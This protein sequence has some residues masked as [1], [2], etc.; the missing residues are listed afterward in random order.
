MKKTRKPPAQFAVCVR[1]K[2]YEASLE[3]GKLYRVVPDREA[4][5]HGYLRIV[6]ESGE[7]YGYA[8]DRFFTIE[9]PKP[10]ER[11]LLKAAS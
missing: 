6:D 2:G 7:D 1:N 4:E 8:A 9:L 3:I 5:G 11:A 10:L